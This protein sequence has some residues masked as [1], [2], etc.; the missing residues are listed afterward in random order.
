MIRIRVWV[1]VR[2]PLIPDIEVVGLIFNSSDT[3]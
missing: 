1:R 3:T 2:V